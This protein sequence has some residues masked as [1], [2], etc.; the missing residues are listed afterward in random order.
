MVLKYF[1]KNFINVNEGNNTLNTL[2]SLGAP[3]LFLNKVSRK[4]VF[5]VALLLELQKK[6]FF[7]VAR[8]LPPLLVAG[9]LK[10][11]SSIFLYFHYT[12]DVCA[13]SFTH[14]HRINYS[15]EIVIRYERYLRY[16]QKVLTHFL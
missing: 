8:P 11:T 12:R 7:L 3:D 1:I 10:K 13:L 2:L 6:F 4:K 5:L 16:V 14:G 15:Q 9:P